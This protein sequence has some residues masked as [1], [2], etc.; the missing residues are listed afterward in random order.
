MSNILNKFN[1]SLNINIKNKKNKFEIKNSFL[2]KHSK[3]K[4]L[5]LKKL[6]IINFKNNNNNNVL[7][8]LKFFENKFIFKNIN[9]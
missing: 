7:V 5:K 2:N 4:L 3:L 8:N 9:K 1:N 6:N